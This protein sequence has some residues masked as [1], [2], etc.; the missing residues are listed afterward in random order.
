[1]RENSF[2]RP[3][4]S[5]ANT[6]RLSSG[7]TSTSFSVRPSSARFGPAKN[8]GPSVACPTRIFST[9]PSNGFFATASRSK[10]ARLQRSISLVI[11]RYTK[12]CSLPAATREPA[13]GIGISFATVPVHR[14]TTAILRAEVM[15]T[16]ANRPPP[17][18]HTDD[19]TAGSSSTDLSAARVGKIGAGLCAARAIGASADFFGGSCG[20]TG[21]SF[22]ARPDE[23]GSSVAA[24]SLSS[25]E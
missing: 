12:T 11:G 15:R 1:M 16:M 21:G 6:L 3:F 2:A 22:G 24:P 4:K 18:Q 10:V 19:A 25:T 14:S 9:L 23:S 13:S 7:T 20:A 17:P 8:T 5:G